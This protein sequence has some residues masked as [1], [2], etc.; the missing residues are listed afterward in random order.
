M[1]WVKKIIIIRSGVDKNGVN[2]F[3]RRGPGLPF[4]YRFS[5]KNP[6]K[7]LIND[8]QKKTGEPVHAVIMKYWTSNCYVLRKTENARH[9]NLISLGHGLT[10]SLL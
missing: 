10:T 1:G 5:A 2:R 4:S 3:T 7:K 9:R 6:K 8:F